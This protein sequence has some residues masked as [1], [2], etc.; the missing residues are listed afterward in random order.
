MLVNDVAGWCVRQVDETGI[1][2]QDIELVMSQAGVSRSH[3]VRALRDNDNDIVNALMVRARDVR[4]WIFRTKSGIPPISMTSVPFPFHSH[5]KLKS[6]SHFCPS[7]NSQFAPIPIPIRQLTETSVYL[8]RIFFSAGGRC[9][10]WLATN[11]VKQIKE[12]KWTNDQMNWQ[13]TKN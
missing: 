8:W 5:Q 12:R 3:A 11:S 13:H 6:R 1:P 10:C 2:G 9:L 4:E 7:S